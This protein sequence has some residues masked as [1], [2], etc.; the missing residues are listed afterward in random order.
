MGPVISVIMPNYNNQAYIEIAIRSVMDQ[1]FQDFELLIIDD[2]STDLSPDIAEQFAAT[3][4]RVRVFHHSENA[5]PAKVRN[6]GLEHAKGHYL[7]FMDADDVMLF[8]RLRNTAKI[9]AKNPEIAMVFG[10]YLAINATGDLLKREL[11]FP[12]YLNNNNIL[13]HQLKRN[14]LW[15][16]LSAIRRGIAEKYR[17]DQTLPSSEDY[18]FFLRLVY[19]DYKYYYYPEPMIQYRIHSN[20]S[21]AKMDKSEQA[22]RI[23]LNKYDFGDLY[24]KLIKNCTPKEIYNCLAVVCIIKQDYSEGEAMIQKALPFQGTESDQLESLFYAGVIKY[25][26]GQLEE[27]RQYLMAAKEIDPNEPTILNNLAVVTALS[28][29]SKGKVINILEEAIRNQPLYNDAMNN[30]QLVKEGGELK[31]LSFTAKLMR[32]IPVHGPN[33]IT[34][35]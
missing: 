23:I 10:N 33:M 26:L 27:A 21:S 32:K 7:V 9:F 5:G 12:P 20:N 13:L 8:D 25:K 34:T 31:N 29:Q 3:S 28:K 18:D 6:I 11:Y 14:Y 19:D 17:F 30:L 24:Q 2:G 16:G 22:T 1:S 35:S 15:T 4:S